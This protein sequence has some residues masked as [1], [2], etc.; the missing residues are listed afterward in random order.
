VS[1]KEERAWG[2]E[3]RREWVEKASVFAGNSLGRKK[4]PASRQENSDREKLTAAVLDLLLH[5][6]GVKKGERKGSRCEL[7]KGNEQ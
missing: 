3:S 1:T 7:E 5:R 6:R 2:E 4:T